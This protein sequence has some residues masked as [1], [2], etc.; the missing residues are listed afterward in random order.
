MSVLLLCSKFSHLSMAST[1]TFLSQTISKVDII[2]EYEPTAKSSPRISH[3]RGRLF[4]FNTSKSTWV[5]NSLS[6]ALLKV[7]FRQLTCL[8]F[9]LSKTLILRIHGFCGALTPSINIRWPFFKKRY[10]LIP[11]VSSSLFSK[12]TY[13]V[14]M[15]SRRARA[16]RIYSI[17]VFQKALDAY[18]MRPFV[19][20]QNMIPTERCFLARSAPQYISNVG[21]SK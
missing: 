9:S 2:R 10:L 12:C 3:V 4:C 13:H 14:P 20:V 6:P 7:S 11:C 17:A 21:P 5:Y 16:L 1:T 18:I 8:L 15:A 19:S